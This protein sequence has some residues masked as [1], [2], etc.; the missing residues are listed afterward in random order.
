MGKVYKYATGVEI[1]EGAVYLS[2]KIEKHIIKSPHIDIRGNQTDEWDIYEKNKLV[3]H[4]FLVED[5]PP[6]P[7]DI[8]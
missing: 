2:T 6:K 5:T 1:P 4:Y 8:R 7:K 3:W